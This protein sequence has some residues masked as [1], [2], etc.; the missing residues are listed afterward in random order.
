MLPEAMKAPL[1]EG[2]GRLLSFAVSLQRTDLGIQK[3]QGFSPKKGI[4]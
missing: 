3:K 1:V 2:L 4:A